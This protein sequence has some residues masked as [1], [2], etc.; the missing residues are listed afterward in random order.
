VPNNCTAI[1]P[2]MISTVNE[3]ND[4]KDL[5]LKAAALK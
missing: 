3:Y 4:T 2:D 1:D 5:K